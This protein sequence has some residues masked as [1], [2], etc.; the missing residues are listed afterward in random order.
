MALTGSLGGKKIHC[1]EVSKKSINTEE[2]ERICVIMEQ[3]GDSWMAS[4]TQWT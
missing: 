2:S 4:S 3:D 1:P